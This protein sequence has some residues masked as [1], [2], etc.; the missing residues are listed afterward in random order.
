MHFLALARIVRAALGDRV[1]AEQAAGFL[2]EELIFRLVALT[3]L[4]G[5]GFE[6][7]RGGAEFW[8]DHFEERVQRGGCRE[9]RGSRNTADSCAA[10]RAAGGGI[11]ALADFNFDGFKRQTERFSHDN[12]DDRSSACAQVLGTH[13]GFH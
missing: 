1:D 13:P 4:A 3:N 5:D 7:V 9:P 2:P 10:T 12:V 6:I 11:I 8:R